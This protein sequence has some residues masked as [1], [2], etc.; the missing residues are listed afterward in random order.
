MERR[1]VKILYIAGCDRSG[2]TILDQIL[3]QIP[4]WFNIGEAS[5]IWDRG[6]LLN[7]VRAADSLC[8]CGSVFK[9]CDFWRRVFIE[10]FQVAPDRFDFTAAANLKNRCDRLRYLCLLLNSPA[11]SL[12]RPSIDAY[13]DLTRKLYT[14]VKKISGAEILVDSSKQPSH[15]QILKL[16][17]M[18]D[19][20]VVHLVR[21]PRGCAYS[22]QKSKPY[23]DPTVSALPTVHPARTSLDWVVQ[24]TAIRTLWQSSERRYMVLRYED[25]IACP[26]E[27]MHRIME[28]VA[29]P[30]LSIPFL[31]DHSVSLK[32]THGVSGNPVR[33]DTGTVR[34]TL[35]DRW[36]AAMRPMDKLLVTALTGFTLSTYGY[37]F[38]NPL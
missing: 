33:F 14:S 38:L 32:R 9:D 11:R 19:L 21:D 23:L 36:R 18:A 3:G 24:N 37:D 8:G 15:A 29:Q 20:F 5:A 13:V 6:G 31:S 10:A 1:K 17:G 27:S 35:D 26:E 22:W 34:L 30:Y 12:L 7:G 16:T 25:L 2:S 28:F 4:G